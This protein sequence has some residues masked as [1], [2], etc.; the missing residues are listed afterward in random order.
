VAFLRSLLPELERV[1]FARAE[2]TTKTTSRDGE[3]IPEQCRP[4]VMHLDARGGWSHRVSSESLQRQ[5]EFPM[6]RRRSGRGIAAHEFLS[7]VE[8]DPGF[9]PHPPALRADP[10]LDGSGH[11]PGEADLARAGHLLADAARA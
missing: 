2:T 4:L 9:R 7:S 11:A 8:G 3:G 10:P 5:H 6:D 1:L